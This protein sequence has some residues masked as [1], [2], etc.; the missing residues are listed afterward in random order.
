MVK[1]PATTTVAILTVLATT[2]LGNT[3]RIKICSSC[4]ALAKVNKASKTNVAVTDVFADKLS[5]GT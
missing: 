3:I 4:I 2:N 1:T 5:Q